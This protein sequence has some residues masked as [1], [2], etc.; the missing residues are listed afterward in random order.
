VVIDLK[1]Q[2]VDKKVAKWFEELSS[3]KSKGTNPA[4]LQK[5]INDAF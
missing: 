1:F 5:K 2:E 3:A 4:E